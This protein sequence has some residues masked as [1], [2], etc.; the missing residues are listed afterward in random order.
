VEAEC[1]PSDAAPDYANQVRNFMFELEAKIVRNQICRAS[2]A[3]M[4]ATRA[5]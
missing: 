3:S 2:R 5:R 4:A 1:I